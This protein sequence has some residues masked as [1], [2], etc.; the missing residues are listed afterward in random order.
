MSA[1]RQTLTAESTKSAVVVG[2]SLSGLMAALVLAR[3]G[4]SVT[5]LERSDNSF[6]TGAALH[7]DQGLL[8]RLTG[9]R[10]HNPLAPGIQSWF[11]VHK[12]LLG[13]ARSHPLVH[14]VTGSSVEV[15]EQDDTSAWAATV[16]GR[17]FSGDVVVGA[18]GH[19]SVVR[20]A[21]APERPDATFAGYCIWLGVAQES[22]LGPGIC[23]PAETA[24]L[25]GGEA[26]LL[27][28][29]LPGPDGS[30]QAGR[31]QL[32]WAWYDSSRNDLF[33]ETGCLVGKVV[34][35][36]LRASDVPDRTLRELW[37][38]AA[39]W[40]TPWRKAVIDSIGRKAVIGTPITEYVPDRLVD[41]R[42][43]LVGDAAHV[44]TPMTGNGFAASMLGTEALADCLSEMA[45]GYGALEA[46][47]RQ[48]QTLRLN[49][50]RRLVQSGQDF[51]RGFAA[52][53][54]RARQ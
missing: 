2:A 47:L 10:M 3:I 28:Y 21:V 37:Q 17:T 7:V 44:P 9:T 13:A 54:R 39:Q 45:S 40:P 6:R 49:D 30:V 34:R 26:Y 42:L 46:S 8:A 18:D 12:A 14:I 22:D 33:R 29:P 38:D 5:V 35:H 19:S 16:D 25:G 24:F 11:A 31:R 20:R 15:V 52:S 32:G 23:W 41:G 53:R 4:F 27:G 51:S 43:A 1:A 48:Y 36:S 50:V